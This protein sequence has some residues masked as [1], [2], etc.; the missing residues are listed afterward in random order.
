MPSIFS[1]L[2]DTFY[3]FLSE[4]PVIIS[5]LP[6]RKITKT[7]KTIVLIQCFFIWKC[8]KYCFNKNANFGDSLVSIE[9]CE[10]F[11][12]VKVTRGKNDRFVV[13]LFL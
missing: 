5:L 9:A 3:S 2:F 4:P 6:I 13:E 8:F 12:D 11:Q 7:L 10:C 1:F